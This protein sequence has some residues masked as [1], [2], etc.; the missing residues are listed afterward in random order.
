MLFHRLSSINHPSILND[1]TTFVRR[2]CIFLVNRFRCPKGWRRL[3]GSCFYL[4]EVKSTAAEANATC[5][6]LH[7]NNSNLMQIRNAVELFY[8]AHVLTKHNLSSMIVNFDPK[9]FKGKSDNHI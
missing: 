9:L 5:N 4:S 6:E 7:S 3:G 2:F 8:A 1:K